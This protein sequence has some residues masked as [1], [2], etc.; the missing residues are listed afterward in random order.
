MDNDSTAS[1]LTLR[2][3]NARSIGKNPKRRHILHY[4]KEKD[5]D[6]NIIVDTRFAKSI[7]NKIIIAEIPCL[8]KILGTWF[9]MCIEGFHSAKCKVH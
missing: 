5:D 2:S 1:A 8:C 6:I 3:Y 9:Y 7:E 4:L